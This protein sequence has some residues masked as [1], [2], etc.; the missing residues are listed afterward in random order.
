V[1]RGRSPQLLALEVRPSRQSRATGQEGPLP[2]ETAS[3]TMS[4]RMSAQETVPGH[5]CSRQSLA[6]AT[7]S[8][9]RRLA[10]GLASRSAVLL[11]VE[12]SS[13]D[14]SQPCMKQLW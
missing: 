1:Q 11:G 5:T 14:A 9:P 10:L 12:S 8:K 7:T 3:R 2:R 4:S 6:R 13:T